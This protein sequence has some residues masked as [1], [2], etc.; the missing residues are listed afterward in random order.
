MESIVS[1]NIIN[2][3]VEY[4]VKWAD[5]GGISNRKLEDLFCL[6]LILIYECQKRGL[7]RK[8]MEY[9][10]VTKDDLVIIEW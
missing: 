3:K 4:T 5:N 2:D 1:D 9:C 6:D 8:N 7:I 10:K